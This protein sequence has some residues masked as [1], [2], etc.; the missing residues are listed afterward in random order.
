V[1]F[2]LSF[3]NDLPPA[4]L[5]LALSGVLLLCGLGLPIPEDISLISGGYLA[6]ARTDIN[7]HTIFVIC[8][9]AV[10]GGD[11][12][13]FLLGRYFGRRLLASRWASRHFTP[14]KQ[15]RVRAYFRKFGSKVIFVARFLPGVRFSI[16]F[17]AGT[18][19]VRTSV[20]LIWDSLA[21]I[22]S[23]PALVY[24]AW[25][26]GNHIDSVIQWV[27]RSESGIVVV[28]A[29]LAIFFAL[30]LWRTRRKQKKERNH[31]NAAGG[32][33]R[34]DVPHASAER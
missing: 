31:L 33:S 5:Y 21:A 7:I 29:A 27:K 13:A 28:V 25:Y 30:K 26:F 34:T 8:F 15:R 2:L 6:H 23:V 3:L 12:A 24:L 22:V 9:V 32:G 20:F 1:E 19:H 11:L 10:I 17:S 16:F 4:L 14:R 18:L